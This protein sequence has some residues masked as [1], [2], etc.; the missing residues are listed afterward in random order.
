MLRAVLQIS[1]VVG[2]AGVF[3]RAA[4]AIPGALIDL[5][6]GVVVCASVEEAE[7]RLGARLGLRSR[8]APAWDWPPRQIRFTRRPVPAVAV[9]LAPRGGSGGLAFFRSLGPTIPELLRP[10]GR[11]FHSLEVKLGGNAAT[12]TAVT[13]ADGR[14]W[15]DLEWGAAGGRTGLRFLGPTVELMRLAEAM[16]E[17]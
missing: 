17:P 14:V 1:V 15:Q 10:P 5:P 6:R 3:L 13:L 16:A 12:L 7:A 8:L 2:L 11:A 9:T 4:D